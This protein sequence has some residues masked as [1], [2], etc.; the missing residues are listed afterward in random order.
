MRVVQVVP[1]IADASSGPS[2]SVPSLCSALQQASVDTRLLALEPR[3]T[4]LWFERSEFLPVSR[5]PFASRLGVSASMKQALT[6]AAASVDVIH[7]NSIWMMPN[8]YPAA[9]VR[10]TECRMV[11]SPRGT[12][13]A[14][15][16]RRSRFRKALIWRFGQKA[17]LEAADCIHATSQEE[18]EQARQCGL[19][20]PVAVIPN[21][22]TCP[23][24]V[25]RVRASESERVL[26][27]LARIH[28]KKGIDLLLR[29]WKSISEAFPDWVLKVAGPCDHAYARQMMAMAESMGLSRVDFTGE[30]VGQQKQEL[31][32]SADLYVLPTHSENFGISV[33]EALAHGVP[34]I[35]THGAPWS[36]L[37]DQRAGWWIMRD[38]ATLHEVLTEAMECSDSVRS[39]MGQNGRRWMQREF[40]WNVIGARM[41]NVYR[42]LSRGDSR[43]EDIVSV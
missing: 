37:V 20:Q 13:S 4:R 2:V 3:P 38:E 33:A 40:D 34:A 39:E 1:R 6:D 8:I 25:Q 21:G 16:L 31:F 28:P 17:A 43:P 22:V 42:W 27:Y 7:T 26:L 24:S 15:A 19:R 23:A 41:A 14:W 30:V 35:V 11:I 36:G 18:L 32:E 5:L 29:S 12:L 10:G 9:A